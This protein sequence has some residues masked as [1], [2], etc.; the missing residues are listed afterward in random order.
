MSSLRSDGPRRRVSDSRVVLDASAL[1]ALLKREAG[2]EEVRR[3][4]HVGAIISTVNLSEVVARLDEQGVPEEAI[5]RA[6]NLHLP[7]AP[8]DTDA[9][10]RAGL[11]RTRTKDLGLGLGDRACLAL[12]QQIGC[13]VLTADQAWRGLA[14]GVTI[15]LIR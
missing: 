2:D 15:H 1:L 13:P 5:R 11:L 10:Y 6:L 8:F 9:A 12:A 3:A 7:T 14:V 4:I